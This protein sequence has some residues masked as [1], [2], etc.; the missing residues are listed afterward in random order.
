MQTKEEKK[1]TI[2]SKQYIKKMIDDGP[3]RAFKDHIRD[4]MS[5]YLDFSVG[6]F[7]EELLDHHAM[8][9]EEAK[10]RGHKCISPE[11]MI[12]MTFSVQKEIEKRRILDCDDCINNFIKYSNWKKNYFVNYK[13]TA[14]VLKMIFRQPIIDLLVDP[15]VLEN[16]VK[17][18][19]AGKLSDEVTDRI[20]EHLCYCGK[21]ADKYAD[22]WLACQN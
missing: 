8:R 5:C 17:L 20:D 14:K 1:C 4:C 6:S 15:C 3:T 2:F 21:C 12:D 11:E 9:V 7:R 18:R 16:E 13:T 10:R 22:R 19:E